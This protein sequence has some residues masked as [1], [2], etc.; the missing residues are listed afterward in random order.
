M[1]HLDNAHPPI[2]EI[3]MARVE[4]RRTEFRPRKSDTEFAHGKYFLGPPPEQGIHRS[5]EK[6]GRELR[7]HLISKAIC[8][9]DAGRRLTDIEGYLVNAWLGST[10]RDPMDQA[11][12]FENAGK[13]L[14]SISRKYKTSFYLIWKTPKDPT[15]RE[16][17]ES[18]FRSLKRFF[19]TLVILGFTDDR[20]KHKEE[21]NVF[22]DFFL[23]LPKRA[24]SS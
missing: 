2:G 15:E 13:N 22:R 19:P 6:Q 3:I 11:K 17:V 14:E 1:C 16:K 21:I 23:R 10:E 7:E 9:S 20:D 18:G 24:R 8:P 12:N 5:I 4:G